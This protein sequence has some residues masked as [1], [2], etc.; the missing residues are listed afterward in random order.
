MRGKTVMV[1]IAQR[2]KNKIAS[3]KRDDGFTA[4]EFALVSVPFLMMI[5]GIL[6]LCLYFFTVFSMEQAVITAS[7]EIR[8][9]SMQQGSGSYAGLNSA[10]QIQSKFREQVC[11]NAPAY[12][13]SDCNGKV[14]VMVQSSAGFKTMVEPNCKNGSGNLVTEAEAGAHFTPGGT[15]DVVFATA[16]VSYT[17]WKL[18][19]F[20]KSNTAFTDGASLIQASVTF[21]TEPY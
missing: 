19:P 3:C 17:M 7:R 15:S 18:I 8:T 16:C 5:F 2:I 9:G 1:S 12:I 6:G 20:F 11:K 4:V 21:R 10:A 13:K 14:R